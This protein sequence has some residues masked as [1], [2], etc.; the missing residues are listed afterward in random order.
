MGKENQE[1]KPAGAQQIIKRNEVSVN[2]T[3]LTVWLKK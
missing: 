2:K 3:L 1:I